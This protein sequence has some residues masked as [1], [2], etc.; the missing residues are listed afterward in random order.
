MLDEGGW[1]VKR[2]NSLGAERDRSAGRGGRTVKRGNSL[3]G[4][5][6]HGG[7]EIEAPAEGGWTVKRRNS[8]G[9][10]AGGSKIEAPD[11]G[12]WTVKRGNSLGGAP[13]E[14]ARSKRQTKVD[15]R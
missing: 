1:T 10:F 11:G 6:L 2:G 15:G 14:G 3:G 5:P 13:P 4:A 12:G 9:S 8:L 7:T